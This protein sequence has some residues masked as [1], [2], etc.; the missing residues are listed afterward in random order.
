MLTV[1]LGSKTLATPARAT[2]L[3]AT[4]ESP[5]FP[6]LD[7]TTARLRAYYKLGHTIANTSS[8]V[9]GSQRVVVFKNHEA[10]TDFRKLLEPADI[11]KQ[12]HEFNI[13]AHR[14][15]ASL[16]KKAD[17][18][19]QSI[20]D[21]FDHGRKH[22]LQCT[23]DFFSD[24]EQFSYLK[25]PFQTYSTAAGHATL[26]AATGQAVCN[27][28]IEDSFYL[29][30]HLFGV[31]MGND[32]HTQATYAK[33]VE[34]VAN[35]LHHDSPFVAIGRKQL[36]DVEAEV[37]SYLDSGRPIPEPLLQTCGQALYTLSDNVAFVHTAQ[38]S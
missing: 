28:K 26:L 29:A 12:F 34:E 8:A 38:A 37:R 6:Q 33:K 10:D 23:Y 31:L 7:S 9:A 2:R 27:S 3:Q 18:M 11:A 16:V 20:Q 13:G 35:S 15:F 24:P 36:V 22:Q 32:G 1:K 19:L 4:I 14:G 17:E 25:K 5:A 21:A 30:L